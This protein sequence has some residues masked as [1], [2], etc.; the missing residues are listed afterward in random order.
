MIL[1][2]KKQRMQIK[3]IGSRI[4]VQQKLDLQN[5]KVNKREG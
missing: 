1:G 4:K 2:C 5:N 3:T